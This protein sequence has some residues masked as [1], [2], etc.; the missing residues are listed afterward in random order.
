MPNLLCAG[1]KQIVDLSRGVGGFVA[2]QESPRMK[3]SM[4]TVDLCRPSYSLAAIT[5]NS[6]PLVK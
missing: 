6:V 5:W 3:K 1:L 2:A 4:H